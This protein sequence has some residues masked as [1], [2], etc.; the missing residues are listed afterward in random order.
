MNYSISICSFE[1][2]KCGKERE[3]V[4]KFEHLENEQNFLDEIKNIFASFCR[5][6][7]W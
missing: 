4:Q 1:S 6:I 3:K 2:G 7:I 5:A